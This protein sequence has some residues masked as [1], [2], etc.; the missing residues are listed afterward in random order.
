MAPSHIEYPNDVKLMN[1]AREWICKTIL[2]EKNKIDP[3]LKIRTYRRKARVLFLDFQ[4]KKKKSKRLIEKSKKKMAS[5]LRRN[6]EQI[7]RLI[8]RYHKLPLDIFNGLSIKTTQKHVHTAKEIYQQQRE[9]I[10]AKS[11]RV[12]NRIVSFHQPQVR[13]ILR[14]KE[15]KGVEFGPKE[16][17]AYVGGYAFLDKISFDNFNEGI[18]LEESLKKHE[19]RFGNR[20]TVVCADDIFS[21]RYNRQLL[22]EKK[23]EHSFK[24]IGTATK[25]AKTRT[26]KLRKLRNEV[27]GVIGTLKER[28]GL[29]RIIYTIQDGETIQNYLAMGVH[30]LNKAA[31]AI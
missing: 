16:L 31:K 5:Y 25:K 30:N 10:L 2:E 19:D 26:R 18:C 24:L 14:G 29:D 15:G 6:I 20:P 1:V 11:T 23:V 8:S 4:K 17:V 22:K 7:E 9:M 13:P 21:N 3:R 12:S 28:W 27:E